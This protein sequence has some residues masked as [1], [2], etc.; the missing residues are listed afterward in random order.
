MRVTMLPALEFTRPD[1]CGDVAGWEQ[2]CRP[3][4]SAAEKGQTVCPEKQF[5]SNPELQPILLPM[6]AS[7]GVFVDP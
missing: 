4:H 5:Y 2:I 7:R 3:I 1:G 6:E